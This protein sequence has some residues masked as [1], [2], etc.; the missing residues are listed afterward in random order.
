MDNAGSLPPSL[1][2]RFYIVSF[3]H[4]SCTDTPPGCPAATQHSLLVFSPLRWPVR[5]CWQRI[6]SSTPR[7]WRHVGTS[8]S[9]SWGHR[10]INY[11]ISR[12]KHITTQSWQVLHTSLQFL[13][14]G[15]MFP[16]EILSIRTYMLRVSNTIANVSPYFI[17]L[18]FVIHIHSE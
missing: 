4:W 8:V 17:F 18:H 16:L 1:R 11:R 10:L 13:V 3:L 6:S 2:L 12:K 14:V 7:R 5:H 9:V 15:Y